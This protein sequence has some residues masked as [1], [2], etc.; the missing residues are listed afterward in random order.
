MSDF[1][2]IKDDVIAYTFISHHEKEFEV[3]KYIL[4]TFVLFF[5]ALYVGFI[6]AAQSGAS[7]ELEAV[8]ADMKEA[9][10]QYEAALVRK[11]SDFGS[12]RC[13]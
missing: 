5:L 2:L 4:F 6:L 3:K 11:H 10:P 13:R 1:A 7:F 8:K 12:P 9:G